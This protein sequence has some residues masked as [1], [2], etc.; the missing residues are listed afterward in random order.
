MIRSIGIVLLLA[1]APA[2]PERSDREQIL[3][4]RERCERAFLKKDWKTAFGCVTDDWLHERLMEGE[5]VAGLSYVFASIEIDDKQV[6]PPDAVKRK[7]I[8]GKLLEYLRSKRSP[9]LDLAT[10]KRRSEETT[11]PKL[12]PA[13]RRKLRLAL[14]R[15]CYGNEV[16]DLCARVFDFYLEIGQST[17]PVS[18]KLLHLRVTG[19]RATAQFAVGVKG[20]M[21]TY[22]FRRVDGTWKIENG[23]TEEALLERGISTPPLDTDDN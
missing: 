19:D 14:S 9:N 10:V 13:E 8:A 18:E 1:V 4:V 16:R 23:P 20:K 21:N 2:T 3:E 17:P 12:T 5:V 7:E 22:E 15:D 6:L 11:N